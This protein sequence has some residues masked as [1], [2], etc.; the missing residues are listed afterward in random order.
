VLIVGSLYDTCRPPGVGYT[1]TGALGP[2]L[3]VGIRGVFILD[4]TGQTTGR[5]DDQD[6]HHSHAD[7]YIAYK[8]IAYNKF[9][10]TSHSYKSHNFH[11]FYRYL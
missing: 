5:Y 2:G 3:G 7:G 11:S 9:E 1:H 8:N 4:I 10:M 6:L